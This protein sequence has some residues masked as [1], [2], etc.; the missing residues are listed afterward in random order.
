MKYFEGRYALDFSVEGKLQ[1]IEF[2]VDDKNA[3]P[4]FVKIEKPFSIK[5]DHYLQN[6]MTIFKLKHWQR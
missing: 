3:E 5:F 2:A 6:P 1:S 4:K